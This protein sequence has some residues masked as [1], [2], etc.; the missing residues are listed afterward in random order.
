[1]IGDVTFIV[2]RFVCK[3]QRMFAEA[4]GATCAAVSAVGVERGLL[5]N[6]TGP[7]N[8]ITS[9]CPSYCGNVLIAG[10]LGVPLNSTLGTIR[11]L[12]SEGSSQMTQA[13]TITQELAMLIL[14]GSLPLEAVAIAGE[15]IALDARVCSYQD[16]ATK[17]RTL[18]SW[19]EFAEAYDLL[20]R[21]TQSAVAGFTMTRDAHTLVR[22][23]EDLKRN[24]TVL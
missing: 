15:T 18:E 23:L 19:S 12:R 20:L 11:F 9:S 3:T 13:K 16:G 24:L 22:A 14:Q 21:D 1:M 5:G 8:S 7:Y 4:H 2:D 10:G 17:R 6:G